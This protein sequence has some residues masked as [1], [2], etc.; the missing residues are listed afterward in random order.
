PWKTEETIVG[1]PRL[2]VLSVFSRS[3]SPDL[4]AVTFQL[5]N[6]RAYFHVRGLTRSE[7]RWPCRRNPSRI[8]ARVPVLATSAPV[9]R[10]SGNEQSLD[11]FSAPRTS[12]L[13]KLRE[14][15]VRAGDRQRPIADGEC[16]S[17][18]RVAPDVARSEDARARCLDRA[19]LAVRQW[20]TVGA[21]GIGPGQ[22]EALGVDGDARG[23][24]AGTGLGADEDEYRR[25]V[26]FESTALPEL[27]EPQARGRAVALDGVHFDVAD[28]IDLLVPFNPAGEVVGHALAN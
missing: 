6:P 4:V 3:D 13:S 1:L 27:A 10:Q 25:A 16:H 20:P 24:P 12:L 28:D 26:E 17:L 5:Q 11:P 14:H 8:A 9:K 2:L 7:E 22:D 15:P 23:Q 21:R 18:R 19:W